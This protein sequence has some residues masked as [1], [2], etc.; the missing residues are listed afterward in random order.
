MTARP[1]CRDLISTAFLVYVTFAAPYR[2][3]FGVTIE[4]DT[5]WIWF[6]DLFIDMFFICD[7]GYNFRLAFWTEKVVR[8]SNGWSIAANYFKG[9]F[10]LD[11]VAGVPIGHIMA[12]TG[13][14]GNSGNT[15]VL[16]IVR[17]VR[18]GRMLR[19]VKI[20]RMLEKR[21]DSAKLQQYLA[22]IALSLIIVVTVHLLSCL[23]F[24]AGSTETDEI[25]SPWVI[26]ENDGTLGGPAR[27]GFEWGNG[28]NVG[29]RYITAMYRVLMTRKDSFTDLERSLAILAQ[30]LM[31]IIAG[32]VNGLITANIVGLGSTERLISAKCSSVKVWMVEQN[33][34]RAVSTYRNFP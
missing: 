22:I 32:S 34:P 8:V 17:L 18:L 15:R 23:W 4:M 6:V 7:I 5:D 14:D 25:A 2:F 11:F 24:L 30:L 33:L 3:C 19:V 29:N 27:P 28:T 1:I 26:R 21:Q 10:V 31:I 13:M 9:W 12:A 16:K 20:K